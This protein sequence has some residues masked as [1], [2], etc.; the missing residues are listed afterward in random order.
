MRQRGADRR[1]ILT[2]DDQPDLFRIQSFAFEEL[3]AHAVHNV[4][5][6]VEDGVGG[7]V[8]VVHELLYLGVDRFGS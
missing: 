3:N 8:T 4:V 1:Q 6:S 7:L 2:S 5:V